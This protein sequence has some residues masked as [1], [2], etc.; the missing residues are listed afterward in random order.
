MKMHSLFNISV[1]MSTMVASK[2]M[3]GVNLGGWLYLDPMITPSMFYR[4]YGMTS[5]DNPGMD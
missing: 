1:L 5:E 4:F 2:S 3:R